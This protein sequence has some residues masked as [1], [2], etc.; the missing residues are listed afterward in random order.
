MSDKKY[1]PFS[2]YY[3]F[4]DVPVRDD[5]VIVL[6]NVNSVNKIVLKLT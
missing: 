5:E 2:W 4:W 1:W 3:I 6:V